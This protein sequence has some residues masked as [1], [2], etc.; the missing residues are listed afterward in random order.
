[1]EV[2]DNPLLVPHN[3]MKT[4]TGYHEMLQSDNDNVEKSMFF[5]IMTLYK[6]AIFTKLR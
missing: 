6:N 5:C 3:R 2:S 1:M 4:T